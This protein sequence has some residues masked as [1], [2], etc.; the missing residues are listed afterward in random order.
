MKHIQT[1]FFFWMLSLFTCNTI[2]AQQKSAQNLSIDLA[3]T[4][5]FQT[6][7]LDKGIVE[8][9]FL[10]DLKEQI[11]L[12]GS[13]T[14]NNKGNDIDLKTPWTG[15]IV[16]SGYFKKPEY[17]KYRKKGNIKV[18]FWLQPVKYY[19]GAAWYQ[20]KVV[21]PANWKN[22]PVEL[23]LERCHWETQIWVDGKFAGMQNSARC[24]PGQTNYSRRAYH[25]NKDR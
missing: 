13:M 20:K 1:F 3:G 14:T 10:K 11:T 4:W 17:A 12:P 5:Q 2:T 21:I 19:K 24:R 7:S 16:D 23:Y 18:P 22:K 25:N 8:K 9:W 6:D 15:S